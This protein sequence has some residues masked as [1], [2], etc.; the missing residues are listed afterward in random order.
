VIA[1]HRYLH[2]EPHSENCSITPH[3]FALMLEKEHR[4]RLFENM[5]LK[6][7]IRYS[8]LEIRE[9]VKIKQSLYKP[10]RSRSVRFS[11]LQDTRHMKVI[12]LSVIR[13]GNIYRPRI[14][15]CTHFW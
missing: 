14:I 4:M 5:A 3:D 10:E 7:I 15:N 9:V 8:R 2:I 12:R 6:K 13:I 11:E 1:Y